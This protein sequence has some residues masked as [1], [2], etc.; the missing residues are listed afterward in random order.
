MIDLLICFLPTLKHLWWCE[1]CASVTELSYS[2]N[3]MVTQ[4]LCALILCVNTL[5]FLPVMHFD[6]F[7]QVCAVISAVPNF[8]MLFILTL[9]VLQHVCCT[10]IWSWPS[11]CICN[12]LLLLSIKFYSISLNWLFCFYWET[13]FLSWQHVRW[14]KVSFNSLKLLVSSVCLSINIK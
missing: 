14:K 11:L 12:W 8:D 13:C 6:L 3:E 10:C 7:Y 9:P 2:G 4:D 5:G 1:K